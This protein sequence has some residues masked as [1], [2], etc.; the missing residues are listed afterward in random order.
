MIA[1]I[2]WVFLDLFVHYS[3]I[4]WRW[5]DLIL[6]IIVYLFAILLP[7]GVVAHRLITSFP[8]IFQHAGWD[9]EPLEPVTPAEMYS[10]RY[11]EKEK[12]RS[13]DSWQRFWIRAA[14]GWVYLEIAAIILGFVALGPLFFSALDMGFGR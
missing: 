4:P 1:F 5:L 7:F 3:P 12:E 8:R 14:Q 6:G 10:V 13:P 11:V 2:G 9:V